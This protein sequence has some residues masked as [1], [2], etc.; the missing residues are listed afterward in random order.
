MN[1]FTAPRKSDSR[2]FSTIIA[3]ALLFSMLPTALAQNFS[4]VAATNRNATAISFLSANG[5][6]SGYP[7][8]TFQPDKPVSRVEF[9]KLALLSSNVSLDVSTPSGFTD[10]NENAWYAPYVRKAKKQGWIQGY[11]DGTFK[12]DQSVNKVEGLK[13]IA[14]IQGW[15][16]PNIFQQ[17]FQDTV[18]AAWYTPFVAY[19]KSRNFL[20]ETT[21]FFIPTAS[22]SRAKTS[23][24]L[25]RALITKA[26]GVQNYT[27]DLINKFPNDLLPNSP[28]QSSSSTPAAPA[29]T[30]PV[31]VNFTPHQ[32]QTYPKTYFD[33]IS[34]NQDLPN[35]FYQNEIYVFSGRINGT[36]DKNAFAFIKDNASLN[37]NFNNSL[38]ANDGTFSIP[39][40]FRYAGNYELG[41]VPESATQ[42]AYAEIT[43]LPNLPQ[44]ATT[45]TSTIPTGLQLK[46]LHQATTVS[47]NNGTDNLAE[48]TFTQGTVSK[49][50]FTRQNSKSLDLIYDDFQSFNPGQMTYTVLS[51]KAAQTEPLQIDTPW[52][53]SSPQSFTAIQH[54]FSEVHNDQITYNILP[55]TMY[56]PGIV[57][58]T[59]KV[60]TDTFKQA[61]VIRP[62]GKV[63]NV[64]LQTS[65]PTS[66]YEDETTILKGGN[67]TFTY[68]AKATGTY[69]LEINSDEGLATLNTP[70]FIGNGIPL[71]PDFFDLENSDQ[72]EAAST[73]TPTMSNELFNLINQERTKAGIGTISTDS[74][75]NTLAQKHTDD[76]LARNYFGHITPDGL[77]PDDRRKALGIT[78]PVGEN[79]AKAPNISYAHYG[80]MRSAIHRTNILDPDWTRVGIG[81]TRTT[82]GELLV[83]EEF[84]TSPPTAASISSMRTNL[85][86]SINQKRQSNSLG[87]TTTNATMETTAEN[88][89]SAMVTQ[90][91]FDFVAPDGSSLS[92]NVQK[93]VPNKSVHLYILESQS[94]TD[95]LNE[96]FSSTD[97]LDAQWKTIGIGLLADNNGNFKLTLLLST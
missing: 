64:D 19:A 42:S 60:L 78:T 55:E 83:A 58:F 46:Y 13:M 36:T 85:Y 54:T 62:D 71:T 35:T 2:I 33:N 92:V 97:V 7:D 59:G 52:A 37:E 51:A 50:F 47:W 84:S 93:A 14:E 65:S 67:Y 17:P 94:Q 32:F 39:V 8:G 82:D 34:L 77:S 89:S 10:V 40:I 5:I 76:M 75:L 49:T 63:D 57:S 95:L 24:I 31:Q 25:F 30:A 41:I 88:W 23:E 79:L 21:G 27:P 22:L 20:E 87:T 44:P 28:A 29:T 86:A 81:I 72:P 45:G 80:L 70:V 69:I 16:T 4:D 48:I 1:I 66:T 96:I 68:S 43:V 74:T 90:N 3:A 12:P 91:F 9:L 53:S 73:S 26:A 6:I 15:Q 18:T 61:A 11:G 56:S 38:T